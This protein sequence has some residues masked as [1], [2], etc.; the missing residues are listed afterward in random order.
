MVWA[1]TLNES[2]E[3]PAEALELDT[4]R[5]KQ[6]RKATEEMDSRYMERRGL[7]LECQKRQ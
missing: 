6:K 1:S 5:K 4:R 3:N 7:D 2:K